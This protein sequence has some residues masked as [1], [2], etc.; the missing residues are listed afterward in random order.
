MY[1]L[2]G[3]LLYFVFTEIWRYISTASG[4]GLAPSRWRVIIRRD[5]KKFPSK[6]KTP[7]HCLSIEVW[8]CVSHHYI[9]YF[10]TEVYGNQSPSP[11][12]RVNAKYEQTASGHDV[13]PDS[14]VHGANMGPI[15][16]RQAQVGPMLAPWTMLS[17]SQ[18]HLFMASHIIAT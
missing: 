7:F 14:N 10:C 18:R 13:C 5:Y 4:N 12:N 8:M 15:W 6:K 11:D 1:F 3:E 9:S 2:E 16:D 17:I